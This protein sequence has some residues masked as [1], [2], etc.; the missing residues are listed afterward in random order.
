[1]NEN[2]LPI[3]EEVKESWYKPELEMV[4]VKEKTLNAIG[5][6]FDLALLSS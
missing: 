4:S 1:M 6:G 5:P 2:E 3:Q